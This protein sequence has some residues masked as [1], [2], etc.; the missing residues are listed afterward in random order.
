M[1]DQDRIAQLE[2]E[3]TRLRAELGQ[4]DQ[5]LA[6]ALATIARLEARLGMV[7]ACLAKDRH[8]SSKPL[9]SDGLARRVRAPRQSSASRFDSEEPRR[10]RAT[11]T[12]TAEM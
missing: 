8:N 7:E 4:V 11:G 1:T 12:A 6:E 10:G 5:Q 9:T 2:A 3:N